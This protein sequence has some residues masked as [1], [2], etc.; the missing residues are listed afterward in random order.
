MSDD[1]KPLKKPEEKP[2]VEEKP[3]QSET[4]DLGTEINK[5]MP[6]VKKKVIVV[7]ENKMNEAKKSGE[8]NK[9]DILK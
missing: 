4:P 8:K 2:K 5:D 9:I 1:K 6:K 7:K 3:K